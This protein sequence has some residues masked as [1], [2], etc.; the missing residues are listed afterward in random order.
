MTNRRAAFEIALGIE[1]ET[2]RLLEA[3]AVVAAMPE[4]PDLDARLSALDCRRGR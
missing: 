1:D 3:A 4:H 2:E